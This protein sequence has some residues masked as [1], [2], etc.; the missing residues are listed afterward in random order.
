MTRLKFAL[1]N[2][3]LSSDN[4]R[5]TKRLEEDSMDSMFVK[6]SSV[7]EIQ[8]TEDGMKLINNIRKISSSHIIYTFHLVHST[9]VCFLSN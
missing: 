5:K 7:I 6:D 9:N 4:I 8:S 2:S 1:N 3:N